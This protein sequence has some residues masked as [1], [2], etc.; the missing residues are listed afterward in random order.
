MQTH[1]VHRGTMSQNTERIS[2][3]SEISTEFSY[4]KYIFTIFSA[5]SYH[6]HFNV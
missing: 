5:C 3:Y 1:A 4:R 6:V 2:P